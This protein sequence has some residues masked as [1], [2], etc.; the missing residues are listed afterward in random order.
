MKLRHSL[1]LF[2]S[3]LFLFVSLSSNYIRLLV[4]LLSQIL[5]LELIRERLTLSTPI[6][7]LYMTICLILVVDCPQEPMFDVLALVHTEVSFRHSRFQDYGFI[8]VWSRLIIYFILYTLIV[9]IKL[10]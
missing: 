6:F 7:G 5:G 3:S 8:F 9:F 2:D 4:M 10:I 1:L